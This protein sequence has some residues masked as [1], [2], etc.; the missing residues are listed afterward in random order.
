MSQDCTKM[1][2]IACTELFSL[3]VMEQANNF[4]SQH[5]TVHYAQR[6]KTRMEIGNHWIE[7]SE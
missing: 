2:D 6:G 5:L 4:M 3:A 1:P 7:A